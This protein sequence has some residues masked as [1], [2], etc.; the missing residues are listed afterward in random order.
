MRSTRDQACIWSRS[1][2]STW[3]CM[4]AVAE[5]VEPERHVL[6][7]LFTLLLYGVLPL[8][9]VLYLLA[10]R[11]GAARRAAAEAG[12]Q[13][14]PRSS[15]TAAAMRPVTPSRRYEKNR[16]GVARRCTSAPP[17][18][19]VDAGG[20]QAVARQHRQVGQPL[21]GRFGHEAP[22]HA[23]TARLVAAASAGQ[24]WPKASSTSAPTSKARRPDARRRARPRARPGAQPAA[25]AQ[26]RRPSLRARRRPVRASRRARR[27][28]PRP[29]RRGEQHRQAVG[30]LH[31]AGDAGLGGDARVGR[32]A[33]AR[34]ARRRRA[35]SRDDA[36]AVHLA[37][38]DRRG[39]DRLRQ[40]AR[41]CAA[42]AA[43]VVAAAASQVHRVERR[44]R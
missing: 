10:R 8:S 29:S 13:R 5:A 35:S 30:D 26:R 9:I 18:Y 23:G 34:R 20:A 37:Q 7:A 16:D 31:R 12:R 22:R 21:A 15:Q 27:R 36:R 43:G 42:T 33:S 38:P 40:A 28:R 39:A 6:G 17:R 11:R 25:V 14:A 24:R 41:G 2:G 19:R 1:P 44:R 4:M 32:A 3:C